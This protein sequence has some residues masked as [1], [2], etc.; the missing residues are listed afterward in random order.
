M[1]GIELATIAGMT[2]TAGDAVLAAS[3]LMGV[4]SAI[5]QGNTQQKI[6]NYNADLGR[7]AAVV[8]E[9]QAGQERA[10]GQRRA[11]A[12]RRQE[13]RIGSRIQ[14]LTAASGGGSLDPTIVDL[15]ADV[16]TEGELRA[17]TALYEGEERARGL[18]YGG[19]LDRA[20]AAGTEYAGARAKRA[21]FVKAG[22]TLLEGAVGLSD[23]MD[24]RKKPKTG[25]VN[26]ALSNYLYG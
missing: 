16:G 25:Q 7:A 2:I 4:M 3:T 8:K 1:T 18:E 11:I 14:T 12:E 9:Q 15:L 19:Q 23:R 6:A 17:F 5:Q 26:S 24:K 10:A 20:G 13:Q 22:A 21:G